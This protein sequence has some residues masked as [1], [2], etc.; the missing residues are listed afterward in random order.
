MLT[1]LQWGVYFD[2]SRR[3]DKRLYSTTVLRGASDWKFVGGFGGSDEALRDVL[4][5]LG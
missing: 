2:E 5:V 3:P 4:E 1:Y